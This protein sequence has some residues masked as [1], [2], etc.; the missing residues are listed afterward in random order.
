M[1]YVCLPLQSLYQE[2]LLLAHYRQRL[3]LL[4]LKETVGVQ[5]SQLPKNSFKNLKSAPAKGTCPQ[6]LLQ[7]VKCIIKIQF[8]LIQAMDMCENI[9]RGT[10]NRN[11]IREGDRH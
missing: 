2:P 7:P 1:K 10:K 9:Y 5:V 8:S 11:E 3:P 4:R 6:I